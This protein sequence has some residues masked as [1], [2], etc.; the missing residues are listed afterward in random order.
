MLS[1][2]RSPVLWNSNLS[3]YSFERL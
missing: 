2:Q 3:F 1:V